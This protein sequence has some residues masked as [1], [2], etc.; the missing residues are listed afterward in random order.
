VNT[1]VSYNKSTS[2]GGVLES[3]S[4]AQGLQSALL[5]AT[6]YGSGSGTY[7]SLDSLGITT[8]ADGTLSLDS[9]TLSNAIQTNGAAVTSFFEGSALNGFASSVTSS[10][11]TYTDP[12]EGAF[13]VDLQSISNENQD[14]T[15]QTHQLEVYLSAQQTI[16]TTK[17]NN[18]DIAIQQ[19]PQEIKQI[20]ALLNPNQDTSSS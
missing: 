8:N 19:L 15:D 2:T 14:L 4:A 18:A 11:N 3:D 20:Q 5:A 6:N 1:Q 10:L 12:T 17:Y 13:T 7:Q 9:S 16:L